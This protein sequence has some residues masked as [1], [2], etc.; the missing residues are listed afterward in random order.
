MEL[1]Q[2]GIIA[3]LASVGLAAVIWT[4]VCAVMHLSAKRQRTFLVICAAGDGA[5]LEDQVRS[6]SLLCC[7]GSAE[8]ILLADTGLT[9]EGRELCRR[10]EKDYPRV[11]LCKAEDIPSY[12]T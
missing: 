5:E 4:A 10:I 9:E 12:I 11:S 6:L 3:F 2:D 1:L 8:G 7:P